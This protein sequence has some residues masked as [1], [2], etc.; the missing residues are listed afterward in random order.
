MLISLQKDLKER[1]VTGVEIEDHEVEADDLAE[2]LEADHE[3]EADDLA[4]LAEEVEIED[5]DE[6]L[7]Q[8]IATEDH[9]VDLVSLHMKV[10]SETIGDKT[11]AIMRKWH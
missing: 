4:D 11:S 7:D 10:V 1:E 6:I 3:V 5:H 2:D 9:Q 8:E